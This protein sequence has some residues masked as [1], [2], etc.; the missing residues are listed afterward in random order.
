MQN[1][2]D[3]GPHLT[4]GA[5]TID[6]AN[7]D[8]YSSSSVYNVTISGGAG[9]DS[10]RNGAAS[11]VTIDTGE[12]NDTIKVGNTSVTSFFVDNLGAGDVIELY[13]A[14][15]SISAGDGKI[16]AGSLTISY[17]AGEQGAW[18]VNGTSATFYRSSNGITAKLGSDGKTITFEASTGGTNE[19]LF[20]LS[21]LKA[22]VTA[23][24]LSANVI[25]NGT[26][27]TVNE[28]IL[29]EDD[30]S[31]G[32]GYTLA[33][34]DSVPKSEDVS[35]NWQ[36]SG[37]TATYT[38]DGRTAGYV[39]DNNAITYREAV[40]GE[41]FT[42]TGVKKNLTKSV[43]RNNV[44][45]DGATVTLNENVLG[46]SD[47][48]ISGDYIL[49]LADTVPQSEGKPANWNISATDWACLFSHPAIR[50]RTSGTRPCSPTER[51][52]GRPRSTRGVL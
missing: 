36:V 10:I 32:E 13:R 27:V 5:D 29:G 40:D 28:N 46:D 45:I 20:D 16:T 33:L 49:A 7:F 3:A 47:V 24:E 31:I 51:P 26:T 22:G 9:N 25:V 19:E 52:R 44:T 35:A 6:N 34:A 42:L 38:G 23:E 17:S 37:A 15:S 50:P 8:S 41:T 4:D 11:R 39:L 21:G 43:L 18:E 48:S 30:L 12:G 2:I 14:V 1:F